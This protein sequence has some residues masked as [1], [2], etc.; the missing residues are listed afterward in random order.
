MQR[1]GSDI[2]ID[3]LIAWGVDTI[4]G[5]PGDGINGLMEAIRRRT[6]ESGRK[7]K[8]QLRSCGQNHHAHHD[9][10]NTVHYANQWR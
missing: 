6:G 4:F 8:I 10:T 5:L 9:E 2:L 7:N 1:N 3:C